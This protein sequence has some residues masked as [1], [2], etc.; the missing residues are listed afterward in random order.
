MEKK[1]GGS[2]KSKRPDSSGKKSRRSKRRPP[3]EEI[4][5]LEDEGLARVWHRA[6][7]FINGWVSSSTASSV[8][9][10]VLPTLLGDLEPPIVVYRGSDLFSGQ[11]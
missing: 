5:K 3:E 2:S 9:T 10:L 4:M 1:I 8:G 11:P 7:P 6:Q